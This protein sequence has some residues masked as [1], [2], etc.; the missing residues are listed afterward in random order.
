MCNVSGDHGFNVKS[1]SSP[2][3]EPFGPHA[4]HAKKTKRK[5]HSH[6]FFHRT[7]LY[8]TLLPPQCKTE[9][10]IKKRAHWIITQLINRKTSKQIKVLGNADWANALFA[11]KILLH[12]VA[13][14]QPEKASC[15]LNQLAVNINTKEISS[16]YNFARFLVIVFNIFSQSQLID[17]TSN[18]LA[19]SCGIL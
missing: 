13:I 10:A 8:T 12:L 5:H 1:V 9:P 14:S 7:S 19:T 4:L 16:L 15:Q 3:R 2:T 17:I 11:R 18:Y 6:Q